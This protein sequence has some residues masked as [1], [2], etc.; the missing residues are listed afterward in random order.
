MFQSRSMLHQLLF[1]FQ[2]QLELRRR[3]LQAQLHAFDP[4]QN[5]SDRL[6]E[7]L[8]LQVQVR[9]LKAYSHRKYQ[10]KPD[11]VTIYE[12]CIKHVAHVDYLHM[13][14]MR[15]VWLNLYIH[16]RGVGN[17][18]NSK[19]GVFLFL[20]VYSCA[21]INVCMLQIQRILIK[22]YKHLYSI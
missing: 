4:G 19:K 13:P 2:W 21:C 3:S 9:A 20:F 7:A 22:A 18:L 16:L 6:D 1:M 12:T 15:P 8:A 14:L 10:R 17:R 5:T 11:G